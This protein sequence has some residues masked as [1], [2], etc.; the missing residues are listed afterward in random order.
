MFSNKRLVLV[1]EDDIMDATQEKKMLVTLEKHKRQHNGLVRIPSAI[2][3]LKFNVH[4]QRGKRAA[5]Q[6]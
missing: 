4:S 2:D 3:L 5:E 6:R 1:K